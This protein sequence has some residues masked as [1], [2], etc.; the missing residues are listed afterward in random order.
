MIRNEWNTLILISETVEYD[1]IG[2]AQTTETKSEVLAHFIS[3]GQKE[4]WNS[5]SQHDIQPSAIAEVFS[6]DYDGQELCEV[7]GVQYTIYRTYLDGD[8]ASLYLAKRTRNV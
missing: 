8:K 4:Y 2:V 7:E 3:I 6:Y 1:D 5:A